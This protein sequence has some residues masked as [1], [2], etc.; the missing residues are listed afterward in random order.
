MTHA[1]AARLH[2]NKTA[3]ADTDFLMDNAAEMATK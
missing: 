1:H 3:S 2:T